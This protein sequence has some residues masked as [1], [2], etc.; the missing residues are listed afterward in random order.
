MRLIGN[1]DCPENHGGCSRAH[2]ILCL[3]VCSKE[4]Y[5]QDALGVGIQPRAMEEL[6]S[7]SLSLSLSPVSGSRNTGLSENV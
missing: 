4:P 5:L 2:S 7:L 1:K 6:F 3:V